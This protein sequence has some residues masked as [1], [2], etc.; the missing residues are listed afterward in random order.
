MEIN[1]IKTLKSIYRNKIFIVVFVL[2][3]AIIG[4]IVSFLIPIKYSSSIR[5]FPV[6]SQTRVSNQISQLS[7][8]A[9][10]GIGATDN[11]NPISPSLYKELIIS[12]YFI[13]R[14]LNENFFFDSNNKKQTLLE[15]IRGRESNNELFSFL[16]QE[17]QDELLSLDE[18]EWLLLEELKGINQVDYNPKD[19]IITIKSQF[20]DKSAT[21]QMALFTKM[22]FEEYLRKFQERK[23]EELKVRLLNRFEDVNVQF[24]KSFQE[25]ANYRDRNRNIGVESQRLDELLLENQFNIQ[26]EIFLSFSNQIEQL[27]VENERNF[28]FFTSLD[29]AR[30]PIYKSSPRKIYVIFGFTVV[31]FFL[32]LMFLLFKYYYIQLKQN[33]D[34][35]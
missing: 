4:V 25:L 7:G 5:I 3:F 9:S 12:D 16:Y 21:P 20:E 13:F 31:G 23:N 26:R 1:L 27:S 11:A 10:L 24:F 22:Y 32:A 17:E 35:V 2:A 29:P 15:Y 19:N 30:L 18:K 33:W 14:L 28:V 8:L 34:N 6:N